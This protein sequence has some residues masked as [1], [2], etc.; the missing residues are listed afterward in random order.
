MALKKATTQYIEPPL[1]IITKISTIRLH[2]IITSLY[3]FPNFIVY[4]I[5]NRTNRNIIQFR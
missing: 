5:P 4:N 3:M 2:L 1:I